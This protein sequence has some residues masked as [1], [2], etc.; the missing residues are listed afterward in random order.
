MPTVPVRSPLPSVATEP[1]P[2]VRGSPNAPSGAFQ[3]PRPVDLS[4]ITGLAQE[5]YQRQRQH[6]DQVAVLDA[7]TQLTKF[8][9]SLISDPQNGILAARGKNALDASQGWE[10][11][12]AD[13]MAQ[14]R[15]GLK[16]PEQLDAF[17]R[18]AHGQFARAN[19]EVEAHVGAQLRAYDQNTVNASL[20][21]TYTDA[22]QHA[23]RPDLVAA[24]IDKGKAVATDW[25]K[26]QGFS[27]E[28]TK[29][30][31]A[32]LVSKAHVGVMESL[33]NRKLDLAAT[34][35][36]AKHEA[37]LTGEDLPVAQKLV[38][39]GSVA[40]E[41]QRNADDIMKTA[42]TLPDA[43]TQA[44]QIAEPQVREATER[45]LRQAFE[46][47]AAGERQQRDDAYEHATDIVRKTGDFD[48]VPYAT[49]RLLSPAMESSL[50]NLEDQIR[51]PKR[52][53][54]MG[55][56]ATLMN[57]AGL[58]PQ[59]RQDFEQLD[60]TEYR[61]KL[62]DSDFER[63]VSLQ[64]QLRTATQNAD[65]RAEE[66][67][68]E[69][70]DRT[71]PSDVRLSI[72]PE[73]IEAAKIN[74]RYRRYLNHMAGHAPRTTTGDITLPGAVVRAPAP[75]TLPTVRVTP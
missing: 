75:V 32:A 21:E 34:Q 36:L 4:G 43:Q 71:L 26:R 5:L 50:R 45:R 3:P 51:H 73:W 57:M 18:L 37:E 35:Y 62:E 41:S 33:V 46:D 68:A 56:Y 8:R 59:T 27:P 63:L 70:P 54:D 49:R 1:L 29:Q 38:N 11:K 55:L 23:D 74:P 67:G 39:S 22:V 2:G 66:L 12:W 15:Q 10:A 48:N 72:P 19:E 58:N 31:I 40:G 42:T 13:G 69:V 61:P 28:Q 64:L 6:A 52:Q 25:A 17:D 44:A 24:A 60:L 14:I 47:K 53:T 65:K 30:A 7:D 20:D 16:T 9:S